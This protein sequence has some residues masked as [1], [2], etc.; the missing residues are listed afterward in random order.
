MSRYL[1]GIGE[2]LKMASAF[3]F[4]LFIGLHRMLLS[5]MLLLDSILGILGSIFLLAPL[6]D[7]TLSLNNLPLLVLFVFSTVGYQIHIF[8]KSGNEIQLKSSGRTIALESSQYYYEFT[9][10]FDVQDILK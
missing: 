1:E 10:S 4:L 6:H 9:G 5:K 7:F 3:P 2:R 8:L